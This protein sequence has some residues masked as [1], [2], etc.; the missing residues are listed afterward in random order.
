MSC[1]VGRGV[2]YRGR[3][4]VQASGSGLGKGGDGGWGGR[5]GTGCT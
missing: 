5:K 3:E 4:G 2:D 1:S